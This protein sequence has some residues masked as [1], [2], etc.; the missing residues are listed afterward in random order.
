[1]TRGDI[2]RRVAAVPMWWHSIDVGQGVSTPGHKSP[3]LVASKLESLHLPELRN[4]T[5]LDIGAWDGY[6]SFAAE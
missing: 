4:K 3:A 6:F 2:E 5:V 1:M